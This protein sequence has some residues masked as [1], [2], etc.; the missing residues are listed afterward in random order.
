VFNL[1][2]RALD[3]LFNEIS[4]QMIFPLAGDFLKDAQQAVLFLNG[5]RGPSI[6][7]QQIGQDQMVFPP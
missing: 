7:E 2:H 4:A 6:P 3:L 1:I 5:L